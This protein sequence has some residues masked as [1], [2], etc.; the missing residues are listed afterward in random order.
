M[1]RVQPLHRARSPHPS[2]R[3]SGTAV[4]HRVLAVAALALAAVAVLLTLVE[5]YDV[6]AVVG[7]VALLVGGWA[8]MVSDTRAER[9]EAVTGAVVAA[10]AVAVCL[11]YGSGVFT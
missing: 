8:Q 7:L 6:G 2:V 1:P 11:A 5:A 9:F 10:V 3:T 4:P